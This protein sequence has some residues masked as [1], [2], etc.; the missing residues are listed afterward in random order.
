MSIQTRVNSTRAG[1]IWRWLGST[2]IALWGALGCVMATRIP[3]TAAPTPTAQAAAGWQMI[4][5]GLE[6]RSYRPDG[7]LLGELYVLRIDPTLYTFR[8]HYQPGAPLNLSGWQNALP[9]AVAFVNANFFD[10]QGNILGMLIADGVMY[11]QSLVSRGGTFLVLNGQPRLRS[12]IYEPYAGEPY[13]QAVQAFP[14]LLLSGQKVYNPARQEPVSRRTVVAQDQQ[15]RV[16]LMVTPLFGL[17]LEALSAYLPT[18]DMQV[19]DALNLDGGGSTMLYVNSSP[20]VR[21]SSFDPVP[22]VL[23]VYSR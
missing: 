21:L 10:P 14:M 16:L 5:P 2:M 18:T 3:P 8:A 7:N 12:N 1:G 22:A 20:P 6:Q 15:G 4:A 17:S 13:E 11:G 19:V 23:A 9:D